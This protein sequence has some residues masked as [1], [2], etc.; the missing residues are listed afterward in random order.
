MVMT[1]RRDVLVK[2]VSAAMLLVMLNNGDSGVER[3]GDSG[4]GRGLG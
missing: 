3:D 2:N 4:G 1:K